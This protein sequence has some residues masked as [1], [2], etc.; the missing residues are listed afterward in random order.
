MASKY[1]DEK[2]LA[3]AGDPHNGQVLAFAKPGVY[4]I[5][6]R[7]YAYSSD[8]GR[9][10]GSKSLYGYVVGDRFYEPAE[11]RKRYTAK[12]NLRSSVTPQKDKKKPAK[13]EAKADPAPELNSAAIL[14]RL[15]GPVPVFHA[16]AKRSGIARFLGE[17][18][19]A[20][21]A[22]EILSVAYSWLILGK[23]SARLY[24]RFC[25][26]YA[27]PYLGLMTE[28][29]LADLFVALGNDDA[30]RTK[31][32]SSLIGSADQ[33]EYFSYDST[34]CKSE[35]EHNPY[36]FFAPSKEGEDEMVFHL[37]VLYAHKAGM[38]VAFRIIQGN[39]PDVSTVSDL[40]ARLDAMHDELKVPRRP[41]FV[42][43]RGYESIANLAEATA[44]GRQFLAAAR[45]LE[46]GWVADAVDKAKTEHD[47]WGAETLLSGTGGAVYGANVEADLPC[48]KDEKGG[49]KS[50]K[51]W[52]HVYRDEGTSELKTQNLNNSLDSFEKAWTDGDERYR[53]KLLTSQLMKFYET[54]KKGTSAKRLKRDNP[55]VDFEMRN[56]GFFASVSNFRL[57]AAEAWKIYKERDCIEKC[58]RGG[59]S[60]L[61]LNAARA[62]E[63][64]S[65]KGRM[66]VSF[67]ALCILCEIRNQLKLERKFPD[68]RRKK[69]PARTFTFTDVLNITRATTLS[70]A[71]TT[72]KTWYSEITSEMRRLLLCCGCEDAYSGKPEY[73]E[74]INDLRKVLSYRR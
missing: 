3:I 14:E 73:I 42:L 66:L 12:G 64:D 8:A 35:A 67:V 36:S 19:G 39:V 46:E 17:A 25:Q 29:D 1:K 30:A 55:A 48:G 72:G 18:Y 49:E 63:N 60:D 61:D 28:Q 56:F 58:F 45:N 34:T 31:L 62:H 65:L 15:A 43:D 10:K 9:T 6:V 51:V 59:K 23:N 69:I 7:S 16:A 37:A 70:Y 53:S 41:K 4:R 21:R 13:P 47:M 5:V 40:L 52:V 54:P 44:S 24:P 71:T 33:G 26:Q 74:N 27:L 22:A 57:S 2:I 11:Y 50:V 32:F 38:P 20:Q 68:G